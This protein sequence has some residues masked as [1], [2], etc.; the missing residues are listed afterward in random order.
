MARL[1]GPGMRPRAGRKTAK[2]WLVSW[3]GRITRDVGRERERA[4]T[5]AEAK[6]LFQDRYPMREITAIELED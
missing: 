2:N 5:S 3:R 6:I 4:M 1:D